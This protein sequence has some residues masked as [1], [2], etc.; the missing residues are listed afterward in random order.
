MGYG[1]NVD[2]FVGDEEH[3]TFCEKFSVVAAVCCAFCRYYV[4]C[5]ESPSNAI[6]VHPKVQKLFHNI[7]KAYVYSTDVCKLFVKDGCTE[8]HDED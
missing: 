2:S 8:E 4:N 7:R 3:D 6:C 5:K 1:Y